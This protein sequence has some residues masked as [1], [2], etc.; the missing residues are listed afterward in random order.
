MSSERNFLSQRPTH[1]DFSL[2][3]Q[4]HIFKGRPAPTLLFEYVKLCMHLIVPSIVHL[5]LQI[6][7][8]VANWA[9]NWLIVSAISQ[10]WV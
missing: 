8:Q 2:C 3:T 5:H 1:R 6:M 10:L 7:G 4:D 9:C